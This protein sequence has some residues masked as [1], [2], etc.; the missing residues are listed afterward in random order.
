MTLQVE[1]GEQVAWAEETAPA[2]PPRRRRLRRRQ[3]WFLLGFLLPTLVLLVA[4][5]VLPGIEA[6]GDS[7]F[8]KPITATSEQ[9]VGLENYITLFTDPRFIGVLGVT[10][11]F[12]VIIIPLQ[13]VAAVGLGLLL[14]EV[15]PGASG[16]RVFVYLPVAAPGAVAAIVWG[17]A[18][19]QQG[20]FNAVLS[21]LSLPEQPFLSSPDQAL[22][23]I[24]V[25]MSWIGVGY[26]TLFVIAGLQDV[27]VEQYEAATLDGA[28]WWRT[29]FSVTLPNLRRPLTFVIVANTVANV[30][31]FVPVS[32]LTHGG[33]AGSTRLIMY[34]IYERTFVL[35]NPN[36]G[37]AEVV[38]LLVF[39]IGIT[40]LQFRML[41]KEES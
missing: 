10:A 21:A 25:L 12:L 37:L 34:D 22:L 18:F 13:V 41:G 19:Q 14:N 6:V 33:P 8:K 15:F 26:W 24:V 29:F 2:A 39:L 23:C 30:L 31:A 1:A 36:L 16:A 9:F 28:G 4:M 32:I 40:A 20:P 3:L 7:F 27:P 5:R 17:I 35:G 11:L 38:V